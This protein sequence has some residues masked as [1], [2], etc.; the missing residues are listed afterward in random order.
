MIIILVLS[1]MIE[2]Y[3]VQEQSRVLNNIQCVSNSLSFLLLPL[4]HLKRQRSDGAV[5]D[6]NDVI[7]SEAKNLQLR[8]GQ[9][10][11]VESRLFDLASDAKRKLEILR[12][13]DSAQNDNCF[14]MLR[15][16][17]AA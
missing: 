3:G 10:R 9:R 5:G 4:C 15:A 7:L 8:F 12:S 1:R 14:G 17:H 6:Q 11:V 16:N 13:A 2:L